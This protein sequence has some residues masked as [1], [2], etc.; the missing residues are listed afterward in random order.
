VAQGKN[1]VSN[2]QPTAAASSECR[3]PAGYLKQAMESAIQEAQ[4]Y[5]N[6]VSSEGGGDETYRVAR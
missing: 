5:S 4:K 3:D 2:V 1:S 6:E